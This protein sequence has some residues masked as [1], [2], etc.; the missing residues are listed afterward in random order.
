MKAP[1]RRGFLFE[2][3]P[4]FDARVHTEEALRHHYDQTRAGRLLS[5]EGAAFS[6]GIM[7]RV[8]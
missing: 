5:G 3:P 4:G 8:F 1:P 7:E 6:V 2:G